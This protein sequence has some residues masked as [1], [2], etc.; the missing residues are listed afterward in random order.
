MSKMR[1][2]FTADAQQL[3]R[4]RSRP[5]NAEEKGRQNN[6]AYNRLLILFAVIGDRLLCLYTV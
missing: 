4:H 1:T 5:V 3:A 2:L 6:K